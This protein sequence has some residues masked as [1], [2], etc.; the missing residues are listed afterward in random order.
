MKPLQP[1]GYYR[2]LARE[3]RPSIEDRKS[4]APENI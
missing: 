2:E 3:E 1:S 4:W